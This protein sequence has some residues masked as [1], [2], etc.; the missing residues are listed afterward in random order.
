MPSPP[1]GITEFHGYGALR[2]EWKQYMSTLRKTAPFDII[3]RKSMGKRGS[4]G[5]PHIK[6]EFFEYKISIDPAGR[7]TPTSRC[8][9]RTSAA[10]APCAPTL[11][12]RRAQRPWPCLA[13]PKSAPD[14]PAACRLSS[15]FSDHRLPFLPSVAD[16]LFEIRS[17][18]ATEWSADLQLITLENAELFRAYKELM[19]NQSDA[20][21][22]RQHPI[23]H[24]NDG[25]SPLRK[26]N[27]DLLE[28]YV[29]HVATERLILEMSQRKSEKRSHAW[30]RDYW[31]INGEGFKGDN[32]RNVGRKFLEG[33]LRAPPSV[34]CE[35]TK[36]DEGS[37]V[38]I[39]PI[40]MA[41][42]ICALR[43]VVADMWVRALEETEGDHLGMHRQHVQDCFEAQLFSGHG[44][45][46]EES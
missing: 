14:A 16:D 5:N 18:L 13:R 22:Q 28:K 39:D 10:A 4:P 24:G 44:V 43:Q 7:E 3:R 41:A 12:L 21:A 29:T 37:I 23:M 30:L 11:I 42:R 32:G 40:D 25:D 8:Q 27:Y 6:E 26:A 17:H 46:S 31:A 35:G 33:L 38:M 20:Q 45:S 1:A 36:Y 2:V 34:V 9:S 15:P 19:I